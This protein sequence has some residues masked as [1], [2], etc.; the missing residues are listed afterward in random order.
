[1]FSE[2][3]QL[4]SSQREIHIAESRLLIGLAMTKQAAA[5]LHEQIRSRPGPQVDRD[6]REEVKHF[7]FMIQMLQ[8]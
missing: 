4:M 2:E 7:P 1:L 3:N 8:G 6:L 5:Q